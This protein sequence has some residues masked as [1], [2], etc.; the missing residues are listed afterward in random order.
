MELQSYIGYKKNILKK[1]AM[2]FDPLGLI[3]PLVLQVKLLFKEA[4]ILYVKREDLLPTEFVVKYNHFIEELQKLP[5]ISVPLYLFID[6]QNVTEL[7]LHSFCDASVQAYS[8]AVFVRSSK[9]N[10]I[11]INLLTVNSKIVPNRK[12]TVPKLELMSCLLLSS[13][14]SFQVKSSNVVS[15]SNSKV[16]LYCVKSVTKKWK[17]WVEN[18]VSKIRENVGVGCWRYVQ[19]DCNSANVATRYNQKLKFEEIL[20]WKSPSFFYE[21]ERCVQD[22]R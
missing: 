21:G 13:T 11:V 1:S 4:C 12:L 5:F 14:L 19:T 20:W 6:Q 3:C 15:W 22:Q 7:E 18:R 2:F 17:I 10:N 8:A 16:A 9:N